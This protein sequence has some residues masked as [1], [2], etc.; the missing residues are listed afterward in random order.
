M[1]ECMTLT[2]DGEQLLSL[3]SSLMSRTNVAVSRLTS[4][5]SSLEPRLK[6]TVSQ[7]MWFLGCFTSYQYSKD[8][9]NAVV[10]ITP[11]IHNFS[12][13]IQNIFPL[14]E[15][16]TVSFSSLILCDIVAKVLKFTWQ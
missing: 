12:V 16:N 8:W 15:Y 2:G 9:L 13:M 3:T 14:T 7:L 5:A 10:L 1:S 11:I 6:I 4:L